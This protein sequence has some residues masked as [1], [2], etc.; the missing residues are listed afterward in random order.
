M[1]ANSQ[2][3]QTLPTEILK[4]LALGYALGGLPMNGTTKAA[5]FLMLIICAFFIALFRTLKLLNSSKAKSA[6]HA[7][8]YVNMDTFKITVREDTYE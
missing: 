5:N 4:S 8:N 1:R 7:Y 3:G 6:S 2:S